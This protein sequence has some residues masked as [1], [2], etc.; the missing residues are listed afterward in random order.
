MVLRFFKYSSNPYAC[1]ATVKDLTA[2]TVEETQLGIV[3]TIGITEI[4]GLKHLF[5]GRAEK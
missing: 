2:K 1:V 5:D 4:S 3:N